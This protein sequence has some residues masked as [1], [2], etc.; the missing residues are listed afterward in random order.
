MISPPDL[1]LTLQGPRERERKEAYDYCLHPPLLFLSWIQ[2]LG[3]REGP[4]PPSQPK[5]DLWSTFVMEDLERG[6]RRLWKWTRDY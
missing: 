5:A 3:I 2:P 4:A 1:S 6:L